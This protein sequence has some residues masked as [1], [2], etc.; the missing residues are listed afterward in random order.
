MTVEDFVLF[1]LVFDSF[2][3]IPYVIFETFKTQLKLCL[4]TARILVF[5]KM[6]LYVLRLMLI[7]S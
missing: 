2:P 4:F 1:I 5:K 7:V 6:P 3:R